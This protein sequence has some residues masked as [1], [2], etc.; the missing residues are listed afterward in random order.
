M[1]SAIFGEITFNS[2]VAHRVIRWTVAFGAIVDHSTSGV[3]PAPRVGA[4]IDDGRSGAQAAPNRITDA[5]RHARARV[6]SDLVSADGVGSTRI[7]QAF[8]Y[9]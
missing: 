7:A 2:R 8:I 5:A 1:D 3:R 9:I 4:R 6:A